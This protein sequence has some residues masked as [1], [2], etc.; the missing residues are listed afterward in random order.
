MRLSRNLRLFPAIALAVALATLSTAPA[1]A[2]HVFPLT[3][4]FDPLGHDCAQALSA[5]PGGA[6][7]RFSVVG[8]KFVSDADQSSTVAIEAGE[9]VTWTWLADHCHSVTF[10][11]GSG[12]FGAPGFQPAQ[13]ELVRMSSA[14]DASYSVT[15]ETPGEYQFSCVH[16]GSIGMT[17]SVLVT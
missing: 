13:P 8:V 10:A 11:D 12:T 17:G 14:G 1:H 16:H 4:V 5:D 9:S 6:A 7:G 3:P 15:F 2:A